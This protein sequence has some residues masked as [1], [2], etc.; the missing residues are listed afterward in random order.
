MRSKPCLTTAELQ[1]SIAASKAAA[2]QNNWKVSIAIVDDGGH[3]LHFERMDGAGPLS[4]EVAL[5]K[6]RAAALTR[7]PTKFWEDRVK[8]RPGYASFPADILIQGGLPLMY[9]NEC[10][11]GIGVSGVLSHEDEKVAQAGVDALAQIR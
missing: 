2:Q 8:D 6:A 10:V 1:K 11:G 7:L 5:R 9:D 3:L 4:A